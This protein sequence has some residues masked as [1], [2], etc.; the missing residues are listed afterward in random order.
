MKKVLLILSI[1][2]LIT[3]C[4]NKETNNIKEEKY[5]LT[6]EEQVK[7]DNIVSNLNILESNLSFNELSN[8]DKLEIL[9]TLINK[10]NIDNYSDDYLTKEN[11]MKVAKDYFGDKVSFTFE[12]I[13]CPIC[14]EVYYIYD[15]KDEAYHY[16][17]DHLG[18]GGSTPVF[19]N[20]LQEVTKKVDIVKVKYKVLFSEY[21]DIGYPEGF[22]KSLE[23][24]KHYQNKVADFDDYCTSNDYDYECDYDKMF[25]EID[26]NTYSYNFK[27]DGNN[28]YFLN[29]T[30][31]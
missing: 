10:I 11:F 18:H 29:Y 1:L 28:F 12:D 13:N 3:G 17:E 19:E 15:E 14:T 26:F 2:F 30:I 23:D 20:S 27:L 4:N 31:E 9:F 8:E 5:T 21:V 16:N 7:V 24:A 25:K 22:Y 6:K